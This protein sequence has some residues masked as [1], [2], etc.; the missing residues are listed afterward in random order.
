VASRPA[1]PGRSLPGSPGVFALSLVL[2]SAVFSAATADDKT[3]EID[4]LMA[5]YHSHGQFSGTVLVAERGEVVYAKGFGHANR[6]W[7]VPNETDTKFLLASI[8]KT[9]TAALVMR[10]SEEG[11]LDLDGTLSDYLPWYRN[12]TGSRITVHSLLTHTSGVPDFFPRLDRDKRFHADPKE[13]VLKYCSEDLE[14]E[15]GSEFGYSNSG[16]FIL[17]AVI[18]EVTGSAFEEV[19]QAE[20]LDRVGMT[21]TGVDD[22]ERVLARRATGYQRASLFRYDNGGYLDYSVVYAAGAVYSTALDLYLWDRALDGNVLLS[23]ESRLAMFTPHH[24]IG[25]GRAAAAYGWIVGVDDECVPGRELRVASKTGGL[26]G[27]HTLM[28]RYMDDDHLVVLLSNADMTCLHEIRDNL[29]RVLYGAPYVVPVE[30]I[31]TSLYRIINRDG[32]DAAILYFHD[33]HPETDDGY[34]LQEGE[35]NG[36]GYE[37]LREG[38]IAE[39]IEIFKLNVEAFPSSANCFDSLG[40]AYLAAGEVELAERSYETAL[41]LDSDS[42]SASQALQVI[43]CMR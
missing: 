28:S 38:R 18:E 11:R 17:G 26:N 13:F 9:F 15:P 43:R 31:A 21:N 19:L 37:L 36:L 12:D 22:A 41:E 30:L 27:F 5:L 1:G 40:E 35:L 14:F 16:Y 33:Q 34:Q 4:D 6:E 7:D 2:L 39:A 3:A 23:E 24:H 32:I 25:D 10:L 20:I 8:T 42:A 29:I